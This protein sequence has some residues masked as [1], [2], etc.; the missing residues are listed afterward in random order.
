MIVLGLLLALL[1][2]GALYLV[3]TEESSRYVLF[4]YAF[5]LDHVQMF[6][7]GAAGA[8]VLLLGLWLM[9]SGSRRSARRHRRLRA[10]RAEASDRVARLEDEK[11]DLE[12]KL[13]REHADRDQAEREGAERAET[14]GDRLV[15]RGTH[16]R[17]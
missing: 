14:T 15:A 4:G 9:G 2:G 10:A 6:L 16:T 1:A 3:L 17:P 11:R 5:E 12:R 8:A 13:K 7:A